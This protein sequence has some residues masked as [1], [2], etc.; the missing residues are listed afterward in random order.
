[1]SIS[2]ISI[3]WQRIASMDLYTINLLVLVPLLIG[4]ALSQRHGSTRQPPR[5]TKELDIID[6]EL[7]DMHC[8]TMSEVFSTFRGRFLKAYVPAIAADWL[9]V[10]E[11]GNN[12]PATCRTQ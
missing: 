4:A 5:P 3:F 12:A 2:R 8:E 9:Q 1:M 7:H 6:E 10:S 11:E